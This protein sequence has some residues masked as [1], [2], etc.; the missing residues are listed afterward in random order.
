MALSTV[1]VATY[2]GAY[3]RE[4]LDSLRC[5]THADLEVLVLDDADSDVCRGLVADL[6][7]ERFR[8]LSNARALGPAR[9]HLRGI[10]EAKGRFV[11]IVNH[12]DLWLPDA[13]RS[14]QVPLTSDTSLVASFAM[15]GVAD[16]AGAFSA[17]LTASAHETWRGRHI[18]AGRI[19]NWFT[20]GN[21]KPFFS[22]VPT[23]M[24]RTDI[25]RKIRFPRALFGAYDAWLG[26]Q[27][28]KVGP[29]YRVEETL[30]L[31]RD[32]GSNLT[33]ERSQRRT[34]ERFVLHA[35]WAADLQLPF[36]Q[37][38]SAGRIALRTA[39]SLA[40]GTLRR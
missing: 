11:S 9:N 16:A 8:Y 4:T 21:S 28:A 15:P 6:G 10:R 19:E 34:Y 22:V 26:S 13:A 24:I 12:D 37:R 32:H 20:D 23:S 5:Q 2:R 18:P 1:L 30:G 17:Q 14:L 3:L 40:F 33:H 25:A 29:V 27:V 38:A 31:W 35:R 36:A 39:A 7:D